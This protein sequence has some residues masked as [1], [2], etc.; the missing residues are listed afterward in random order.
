M[1]YIIYINVTA[2]AREGAGENV[3]KKLSDGVMSARATY[4]RH[5]PWQK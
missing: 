3:T 1:K 5:R 2:E 4:W